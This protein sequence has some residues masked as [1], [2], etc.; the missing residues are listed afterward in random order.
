MNTAELGLAAR[1]RPAPQAFS[2]RDRT[3]E[4]TQST[5]SPRFETDMRFRWIKSAGSAMRS[6]ARSFR[7]RIAARMASLRT[8]LR[9]LSRA[10]E[11]FT[12]LVGA[13]GICLAI[14]VFVLDWFIGTPTS[15]PY[16]AAARQFVSAVTDATAIFE[17]RQEAL[18]QSTVE[19]LGRQVAAGKATIAISP[20]CLATPPASCDLLVKEGKDGT[21]TP[22]FNI[23]QSKSVSE[24]ERLIA[25]YSR[26]LQKV[27]DASQPEDFDAA[28]SQISRTVAAL[29]SAVPAATPTPSP[30]RRNLWQ[31]F[32]PWYV[33][34]EEQRRTAI[35]AVARAANPGIEAISHALQAS[36]QGYS[37][38]D[39]RHRVEAMFARSKQLEASNANDGDRERAFTEIAETVRYLRV[40][41]LSDP[42]KTMS[43][44][45]AAHTALL[46]SFND[47]D[48]Q[49]AFD[50]IR[51]TRDIL[52][53]WKESLGEL[54]GK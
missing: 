44:L 50:A 21:L 13:V 31:V 48:P 4:P 33:R 25:E 23:E 41:G 12:R 9:R 18:R 52:A 37:I 20:D 53:G 27:L 49:H 45:R 28:I 7:L 17:A 30:V 47:A 16:V 32:I 34:I 39:Q 26:A 22:L 54:K 6:W 42:V 11:I 24:A 10:G 43:T 36:A 19:T 2:S 8:P 40:I 15:P 14:A 29:S 3:S 46:Q 35:Y 38:I 51:E 1:A 5:D